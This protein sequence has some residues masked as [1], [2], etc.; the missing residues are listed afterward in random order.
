MKACVWTIRILA[1]IGLGLACSLLAAEPSY[2][3]KPVRIV[4]PFS[5][6]GAVDF[7]ARMVSQKMSESWGQPVIVDNRPGAG[8][9]IGT[10]LVE[11]ASPDGYTMLFT[12]AVIAANVSLYPG[13]RHPLTV[14]A[15]L[16]LV[17]QAPFVL[18]VN[19]SLPAKTVNDLIEL[20]KAKPQGIPYGSAGTGTTT[21]LMLELFR[22][23]ANIDML[24]VPYK[25]GAPAMNALLG[26]EVQATFLPI[27]LVL[28]QARAGKVRMLGI[29]S[30][31]RVDL[32]P[33]LPT[34]AESGLPGFDPVGWYAMFTPSGVPAGTI[35]RI[36]TEINRI[37]G[38]ADVRKHLQGRG[39]VPVGGAPNDLAEYLSTEITRWGK[40][41]KAAK[42]KPQ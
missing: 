7:V 25:G 18:A 22:L 33:D 19:P 37:V 29:T 26:G 20:A 8:T 3:S 15:P 38:L 2:P 5:P 36:N 9:R 17:A 30:G 31:K 1:V 34:I 23:M 10:D 13:T 24:H 41:I 32:A 27:T 39:M 6:G 4:N 12:S 40:V 14:L 42:I 11:N 21:H 28:P 35:K 16:A